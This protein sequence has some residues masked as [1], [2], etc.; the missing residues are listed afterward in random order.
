MLVA[1]SD[2]G[3]R[4]SCSRYLDRFNFQVLQAAHGEQVLTQ[5]AAEPPHVILAESNLPAMPAWR[6]AQWLAQN[7]RTRHVPVIVLAGEIDSAE[8]QDFR[9]HGAGVLVKPF[10]LRMMLDEIRRVLR[11]GGASDPRPVK[12]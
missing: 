9:N 3:V 4:E 7:W 2:A 11:A 8:S 12:P 1:E 5:V 6:L 10:S